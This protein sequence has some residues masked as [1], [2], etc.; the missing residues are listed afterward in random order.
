VAGQNS[1]KTDRPKTDRR[2]RLLAAGLEA[3]TGKSYE[4][5]SVEEIAELAGVAHGLLFHYFGSKRQFCIE[6][7]RRAMQRQTL[8]FEANHHPDPVRWLRRELDVFL[9]GLADG[10]GPYG[11]LPLGPAVQE[12]IDDNQQAAVARVISRMGI[13]APSPLLRLALRGW[14]GFSFDSGRQ[15]LVT[16]AVSRTR[17]RRML[18]AVLVAALESVAR[19]EPGQGV[20]PEMFRGA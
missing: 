9:T 4:E 6:I 11:G 8:Q 10:A 7:M 16:P 17:M 13:D 2:E 20:D 15:W 5:V 18:A 3:F 14:V 1:S 12:M 19:T